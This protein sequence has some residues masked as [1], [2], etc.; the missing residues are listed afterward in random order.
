MRRAVCAV[1]RALTKLTFHPFLKNT[2]I[3]GVKHLYG[4]RKENCEIDD[5]AMYY[6]RGTISGANYTKMAKIYS[7]LHQMLCYDVLEALYYNYEIYD[8]WNWGSGPWIWLIW[9]YSKVH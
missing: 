5:S 9:P 1:C 2:A 6:P 7:L 3:F 4:K 8:P